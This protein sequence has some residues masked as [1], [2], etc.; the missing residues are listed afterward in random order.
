MNSDEKNRLKE[1]FESAFSKIFP[2]LHQFLQ[3][4]QISELFTL[5]LLAT[6]N[7][8][9]PSDS[10]DTLRC[11]SYWDPRC[12]CYKCRTCRVASQDSGRVTAL[13]TDIESIL[14]SS[15]RLQELGQQRASQ[16][17]SIKDVRFLID[18][19][20]EIPTEP[21]SAVCTWISDDVLQ[22]SIP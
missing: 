22:C 8:E 9:L 17:D 21:A 18:P 12:L 5:H 2:E 14:K 15:D 3:S 10:G 16:P 1:E 6:E 4:R 7:D 13:Y 20:T 19:S 11:C